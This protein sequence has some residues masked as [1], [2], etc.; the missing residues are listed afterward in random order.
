M[1]FR[2]LLSAVALASLSTSAFAQ[3][4]HDGDIEF[5]YNDLASPTSFVI[6]ADEFTTDGFLYFESEMAELDPGS[7][8]DFF[9][10]EP[11]FTT[12]D[13][14]GLLVNEDDAIWLNAVDASLHSSFGVGYVNFYNASTGSFDALGRIGIYD[15]SGGTSD[16]ILNG[17]SIESGV[18]P[19]FLGLGDIDGDVHDHLIVDLLDDSSAPL[20]AYGIMFQL[21]ADFGAA[22]SNMDVSSDPFWIVWNHGMSESDF[23]SL[24][25]PAFGVS[26]IPEPGT[27]GLL[28]VGMAG[29]VLRRRKRG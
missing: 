5:G 10:D 20:G 26:A 25:L 3:H 27:L 24:A 8:G 16:L 11:G 15:N 9:S 6:E 29:L 4:G 18:N 13:V 28:G 2:V 17:G 23:D 1:K 19:Q 21:Q 14:E 7:P 22:D 12:N